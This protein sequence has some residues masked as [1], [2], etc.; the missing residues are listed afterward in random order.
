MPPLIRRQ[1]F[2]ERIKALLN[3]YDFL[4]WLAE[5]LHE[6]AIDDQLRD[7]T[8]PI[9]V[10]A[11]FIFMIARAN[12]G[13]GDGGRSD[14][15]FGD[16]DGR[17]GSGWFA[18]FAS[19]TANSLALLSILNAVYLFTRTR[20]YRLFESNVEVPPSTPSARRVKVDSSP[21]SNSPLAYFSAKLAATSAAA[22]ARPDEKTD[23]W[24][25]SIWD[26]KPLHLSLFALFSPGHVL[27]YWIFLPTT[28]SDPRP[29]VTVVTTIVL[30]AVLSAQ[31]LVF[32]KFF[33]QKATDDRL[34]HKEVLNEYDTKFVHPALNKPVRD[35]GTQ[36]RESAINPGVRSREVEVYTPTTI[37][38]RGWKI[39]PN[40]SYAAHLGDNV[41]TQR[42]YA[43]TPGRQLTRTPGPL[44][45][46]TP[47][48]KSRT[49]SSLGG[50]GAMGLNNNTTFSAMMRD[51]GAG[52][53][54]TFSPPKLLPRF[55]PSRAGGR[56][57]PDFH[58]MAPPGSAAA[59]AG[60]VGDRST[61]AYPRTS[62]GGSLGVY[63]HAA[64]PVRKSTTTDFF[65]SSRTS[66]HRS[67][68]DSH[69]DAGRDRDARGGSPLKRVSTP[70]GGLFG[71]GRTGD[72]V[73]D[74]AARAGDG[75]GRSSGGD[76]NGEKSDI[77][78]RARLEG[79]RGGREN[80][81][82]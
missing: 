8:I 20:K 23:V 44:I 55:A 79:L 22:R 38:N 3:P 78:L 12:A 32:Q 56:P 10:A 73:A 54:T 70:G 46:P 41:D 81:P 61:S 39:N 33:E 15:V 48:T 4:L 11:N 68:R 45:S 50:T 52:P 49:T 17:G 71:A 53:D 51:A 16:F 40:P 29:S 6:S 57:A 59:R 7:W 72:R 60:A 62:D 63:S 35:V 27:V 82:Y 28:S 24:E 76:G 69:G 75:T 14:D 31:L 13:T 25:L 1:P 43:E 26:P 37:I 74:R 34:L 30:A 66:Q 19:L 9:G 2:S 5:E 18:F 65:P 67:T 21:M 58:P 80:R 64:S 77:G 47:L 36:S 42:L